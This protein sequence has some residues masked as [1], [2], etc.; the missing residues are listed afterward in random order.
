MSP[1]KPLGSKICRWVQNDG[2]VC[3]KAFSKLDSLRRHVNELHK[4]VRPFAC[5]L[6]DKSYGRRDYLDR[7]IK[8]HDPESQKK[9]LSST[10]MSGTSSL[11]WGSHLLIGDTP[12]DSAILEDDGGDPPPAK[13]IKKKRKDIPAE[14]K[15][16]CLWV[17][18][19]GTACGKTFT[20]FDSL[21]RH[22]SE[23]HKGVRPYTCSLCGKN[24]GRRDYLLRHLKSH[25]ESDVAGMAV[26]SP[27]HG[28]LGATRILTTS[29]SQ[30]VSHFFLG[31]ML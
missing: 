26:S 2:T 25:N 6:C 1:S 13:I 22:V 24:Y 21:K 11:E 3:G 7:H 9:K 18:E 28:N 20:K 16:I 8:V 27:P 23:A 15:K 17:L 31:P 30:S 12:G 10:S 4:G 14:E 19:D 5:S 29:S